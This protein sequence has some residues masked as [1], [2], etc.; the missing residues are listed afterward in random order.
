M[1]DY[2]DEVS[3]CVAEDGLEYTTMEDLYE[4]FEST[5][6]DLQMGFMGDPFEGTGLDPEQM[7]NEEIDAFFSE[8]N[9]LSDEDREYLA[10][11]QAEEL[12][13][14]KA[15]VDCGGGPLNEQFVLGAIRVEYEQE[16]LDANADRLSELE[17]SAEGTSAVRK[18]PPGARQKAS[19][20][21]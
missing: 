14:A 2:R 16:L 3:A 5:M 9:L 21:R 13:L 11:V 10:E 7:T 4:E 19:R 12:E 15:V 8:M 18:G 20:Q 6:Q 17:G 1:S